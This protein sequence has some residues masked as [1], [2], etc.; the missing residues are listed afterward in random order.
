MQR[1]GLRYVLYTLTGGIS[2]SLVYQTYKWIWQAPRC[3]N[4]DK[5][6]KIG[7]HYPLTCTVR[8][9]VLEQLCSGQAT[10]KKIG[11]V[12]GVNF[13]LIRKT[14]SDAENFSFVI[15]LNENSIALRNL[16]NDHYTDDYV[17]TLAD[18]IMKLDDEY[19]SGLL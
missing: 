19:R 2:A 3:P 8:V 10:M 6:Q 9:P 17:Q 13:K 12:T 16:F 14:S 5:K 7:I 18:L 15:H 11:A 1:T 4:Y